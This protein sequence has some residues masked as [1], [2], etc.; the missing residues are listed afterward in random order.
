MGAFLLID[1]KYIFK[2]LIKKRDFRYWLIRLGNRFDSN[3]IFVNKTTFPEIISKNGDIF[4]LTPETFTVGEVF[5]DYSYTDI[6]NDDI[7]I[8]IGANIGGFCLP[9]SRLSGSVYAIEP[10]MTSELRY[11]VQRN[12]LNVRIL[13][14]ALGNG[15][16]E[17]VV[18]QDMQKQIQTLSF[19]QIK[20]I[21]GGCDFLKCD[22]EGFEWF[23][24]PEDLKGIR[25]IEMEIHDYNPSPN[26]PELLLAAI[27]SDFHVTIDQD[28]SGQ[29]EH[30]I[31]KF[32]FNTTRVDET[33]ILHAYRK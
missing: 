30:K 9:A 16:I 13:E 4:R 12:N 26:N 29:I 25:R 14:N 23:I 28:S 31:P 27:Q 5:R 17:S 24:K 11:N 22:C 1:L 21:S 7:V 19:T 6:K 15:S 8:D 32:R 10:I 20:E 33:A 2:D 3:N 18:W